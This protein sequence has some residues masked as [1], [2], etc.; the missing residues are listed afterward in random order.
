M[1][2]D[3]DLV[4]TCD[5]RTGTVLYKK[6]SAG[7]NHNNKVSTLER[8]WLYFAVLLLA[9]IMAVARISGHSMMLYCQMNAMPLHLSHL[10]VHI[11]VLLLLHYLM[12]NTLSLLKYKVMLLCWYACMILI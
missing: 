6:L 5:R 11:P 8:R 12:R 1:W 2:S 10:V 9:A 3:L 4:E 7:I